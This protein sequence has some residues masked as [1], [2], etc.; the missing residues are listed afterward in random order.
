MSAPMKSIE[1]NIE[2]LRAETLGCAH[3]IHLNNAG[4]ALMPQPVID[5]MT[6]HLQLEATIGGYEAARQV[7]SQ[8]D[9]TYAATAKLIG[10]K[11]PEVALLQSAT[12]AWQQ[13]FY[14]I[15]FSKG[16][17]I[18]TCMSEYASN[19]IAYLQVAQKTGAQV[20]VIPNDESGQLSIS[21]LESMMDSRVKL[22]AITHIPTNGGLVNPAEAVG[23]IARQAGVPFLL[24]ACQ[25]AGQIPID[26]AKIGCDFLSATSRKYLRGPR[27]V[28]FLYVSQKYLETLEPPTLDLHSARLVMTP[29]NAQP[30]YE[31]APDARRF[32]TWES[33]YINNLG[34][35]MAVQY[36]LNLGVDAIW[37][38]I[39]VL[40]AQLRSAL[41]SIPGVTVQDL[42]KQQ[43]GIIS[44]TMNGKTP[45]AICAALEK[46]EAQRINL[47]WSPAVYT[48]LDMDSRHLD[49]IARASVHYYNT[50]AEIDRFCEALKKL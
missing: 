48:L 20:D 39:Q 15:P 27:G 43:C 33:S 26:V 25:T 31:I 36:A 7:Q 13:A 21:A 35:G 45:E 44:F 11:V 3:V 41:Q 19:Y 2:T 38:R 28:G 49:G 17:R 12:R 37:A 18:L 5:A 4:A 46:Q 14:A 8:I 29:N 23:K 50:E 40:A 32:E 22:I 6:A 16:D 47:S 10:A 30:T 1:L 34:Y 42:G 24:D 9:E